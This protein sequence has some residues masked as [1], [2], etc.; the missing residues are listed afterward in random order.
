[1]SE[2]PPRDNVAPLGTW[3]GPSHAAPYAVSRMAPSF[4]LVNVAEEIER[5]DQTIATMATGKLE[6]IARQMRAL[7]DEAEAV[8]AAAK[9]DAELHRVKC[10]FEKK[11]GGVYHLYRRD[12][13]AH[14]FSLMAP[15]EWTR[16]YPQAYVASYRLEADASFT[17]LGETAARDQARGEALSSLARLGSGE[18]AK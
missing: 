8:L 6:L 3:T 18:A 4:S 11:P 14:Y 17:P 1:M 13:G 10:N 15:D 7:R 9:R 12:S 5:A 2:P 16:A